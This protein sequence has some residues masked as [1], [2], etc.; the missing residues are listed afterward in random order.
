[1]G[2]KARTSK[3]EEL[4]IDEDDCND[5]FQAGSAKFIEL[6]LNN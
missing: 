4:L 5:C 3:G 2:A 1:M 6:K